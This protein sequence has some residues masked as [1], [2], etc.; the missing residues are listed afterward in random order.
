MKHAFVTGLAVL[1][2]SGCTEF[3]T[4]YKV[5]QT[6]TDLN[7]DQAQCNRAAADAY[8]PRIVTDWWPI[9]DSKGRV[10]S[11]RME[12]YDINEGP[13]YTAARNCMVEKGYERVTIPYCKDEQLAGRNYAKIE[14]APELTPSICGLRTEGGGRVLID[15]SKP[16]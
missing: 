15:L 2:L 13:R 12:Q 8:P 7:V 5:G 11:Q 6:K 1:A 3:K 9:Y 14:V 10:V 16:I 4:F